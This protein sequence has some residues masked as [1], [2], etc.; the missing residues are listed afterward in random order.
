M[1][2]P[3]YFFNSSQSHICEPMQYLLNMSFLCKKFGE[4]HN[5]VSLVTG[6][7][8]PVNLANFYMG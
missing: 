1:H 8:L 3:D 5:I 6:V 4:K 2:L 7:Y